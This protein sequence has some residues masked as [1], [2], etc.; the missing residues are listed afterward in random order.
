MIWKVSRSRASPAG[1]WLGGSSLGMNVLR[2]GLFTAASEDFRTVSTC[3]SQT[4]PS[5]AN[6]WAANSADTAARQELVTST[7]LR[8]SALF[9]A[10]AFAGLGLVWLLYVL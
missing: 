6:A 7:S 9:A 2:A 1:N 5:P 4:R 8:R 3:S 10:Q